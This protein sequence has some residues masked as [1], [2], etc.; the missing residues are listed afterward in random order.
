[1][2]ADWSE[3]AE[4]LSDPHLE[5]TRLLVGGQPAFHGF[6]FSLVYDRHATDG[7][8]QELALEW[9]RDH[10]SPSSKRRLI[11]PDPGTGERINRPEHPR[12]CG[13]SPTHRMH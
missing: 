8:L 4:K 9:R 13:T 11:T 6:L 3:S 5:F 1:M 7:L 10:N 2:S 12:T